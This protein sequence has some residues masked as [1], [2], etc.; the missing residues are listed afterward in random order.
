MLIIIILMNTNISNNIFL[1]VGEN[2]PR[3]A[4]DLGTRAPWR[5]LQG[6]RDQGTILGF[7]PGLGS[8]SILVYGL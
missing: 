4:R 5:G 8:R 1:G 2:T 7:C 3:H 6:Q